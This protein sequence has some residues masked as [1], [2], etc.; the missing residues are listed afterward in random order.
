MITAAMADVKESGG[1]PI[2]PDRPGEASG[3]SAVDAPRGAPT[4]GGE[5]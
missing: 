3:S 1:R 4:A 2:P 5:S